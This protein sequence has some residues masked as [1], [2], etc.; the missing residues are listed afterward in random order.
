[1]VLTRPRSP[2]FPAP[3]SSDNT[4]T[5]TARAIGAA[6]SGKPDQAEN[7]VAE[8]KKIEESFNSSVK[9]FGRVG[10][11]ESH[12]GRSYGSPA[13]KDETTRLSPSFAKSPDS[14]DSMGAEQA[15]MPAREMLAD[16]LLELN[17][18]QEALTE[19]TLA[20]RI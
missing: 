19:Y 2:P 6:R 3:P 10:C 4:I 20:L 14:E 15:W 9:I 11:H 13:L 1:M 17:R 8:L 5:Y 12:G 18:P 7:D 16:M